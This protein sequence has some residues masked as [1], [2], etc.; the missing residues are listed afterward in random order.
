VANDIDDE[1]DPIGRSGSNLDIRHS[2]KLRGKARSDL[3]KRFP[4]SRKLQQ[5]DYPRT[6]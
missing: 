1:A 3:R 4:I 2:E 5:E 6:R